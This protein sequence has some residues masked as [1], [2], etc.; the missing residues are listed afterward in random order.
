MLGINY[1]DLPTFVLAIVLRINY[2]TKTKNALTRVLG[3]ALVEYIE[4]V[5]LYIE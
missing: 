4:A 1:T 3:C 2:S 5:L